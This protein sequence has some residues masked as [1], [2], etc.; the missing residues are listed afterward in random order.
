MS[1]Y[2]LSKLS[3]LDFEELILDLL[4]AEWSVR[5]ES[6]TSGKD[7]GIDLRHTSLKGGSVIVQ[8]KHY[9][10]SGYKRLLNNLIENEYKKIKALNPEQYIVVTSVPLTPHKKDE[11]K[12]SLEPYVQSPQDIYGRDEIEALIRQ[13]P[14]VEKKH[15]KLWLTSTAVLENIVHA[16]ESF[17]ISSE[18]ERIQE[19]LPVLVQTDAYGRALTKLE[20]NN[21]VVV[22][23]APG[24]GKS[25]LADMLILSHIQMNYEPIIVES[26]IKEAKNMYKK[27]KRQVI[28]FDDFLG[29]TFLGER[30]EYLGKNEDQ[31]VSRFIDIVQRSSNKRFILT[32]REHIFRDALGI[33]DRFAHINLSKR[34][35]V[36]TL[37]DY[38]RWHKGKMLFNHLY[39]S[40][41]PPQF[42][43]E[44]MRDNFFLEI[45]DHPNFNPR[46]I[47][48]LSNYEEAHAVGLKNYQSH[49]K[50]L[51]DYP[52]RIWNH[53]FDHQIDDASRNI[54]FTL[55]TLDST[56]SL[57]HLE[58]AFISLHKYC[59]E[60]YN[61]S[62]RK[63]DFSSGIK[64]IEGSFTKTGKKEV[65]FINPSVEDFIE[66][67]LVEN[68]GNID[69]IIKSCV[70][71]KQLRV[72]WNLRKKYNG[73]RIV[74]KFREKKSDV[75]KKLVEVINESPIKI[76]Q[77]DGSV[78]S[79]VVDDDAEDKIG[80]LKGLTREV[81]LNNIDKIVE[82]LVERVLKEINYWT[83]FQYVLVD[84][85]SLMDEIGYIESDRIVDAKERITSAIEDNLNE[86]SA[87]DWEIVLEGDY[88]NVIERYIG[89]EVVYSAVEHYVREG[90]VE[91]IRLCDD[92]NALVELGEQLDRLEKRYGL[93]L[94]ESIETLNE[95]LAEMESGE[96]E[97]NEGGLRSRQLREPEKVSDEELVE[98]F[99][100]LWE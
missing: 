87:G 56:A 91:E 37:D 59:R 82:L 69:D 83:H 67:R 44:I 68:T 34:K 43:E 99:R 89:E 73:A 76:E 75:S 26:D 53:A 16:A 9:E 47:E 5:I 95:K 74:E 79:S 48:W 36:I 24:I 18:I 22:T 55:Y 100:G 10:R 21:V 63:N 12:E 3:S 13:N 14:D 77:K 42:L 29:R 39:F 94:T 33:S 45:I 61:C 28:Y 1:D 8:C 97:L 15:Y 41:V 98:L 11:I 54:L 46:V 35:C 30:K 25:T 88:M 81:S 62:W 78:L 17:N 38:D 58:H 7:K 40:S 64:K 4:K 23:G 65:S 90:A 84:C 72:L 32:S 57:E 86:T 71:T 19:K 6:F 50:N 85:T 49:I 96:Q 27:D 52:E 93:G 60:Q 70:A 20:E 80:F 66:Y 2:N 92:E 31:S 51:M